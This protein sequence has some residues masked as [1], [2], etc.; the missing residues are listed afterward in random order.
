MSVKSLVTEVVTSIESFT[1]WDI[2]PCSPVKVNWHFGRR[3]HLH[4]QGL[5]ISYARIQYEAN[6]KQNLQRPTTEKTEDIKSDVLTSAITWQICVLVYKLRL[7][8]AYIWLRKR[9]KMAFMCVIIPCRGSSFDNGYRKPWWFIFY[10]QSSGDSRRECYKRSSLFAL[11]TFKQL[12][13]K[14]MAP[15]KFCFTGNGVW[16]Q[17]YSKFWNYITNILWRIWCFLRN[18]FPN[19]RYIRCDHCYA[20]ASGTKVDTPSIILTVK[21][22]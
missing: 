2:T 9:Y 3:L 22:S 4:H 1:F 16:L 15:H 17:D 10:F 19:T 14:D 20:T 13:L 21:N 8:F 6:S 11:Q 5:R 12:S 7:R 18:N